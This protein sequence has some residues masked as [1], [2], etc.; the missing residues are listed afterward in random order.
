MAEKKRRKPFT[1]DEKL[2]VYKYKS[3]KPTASFSDVGTVL[4]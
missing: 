3:E 4:N 1:M 2:D